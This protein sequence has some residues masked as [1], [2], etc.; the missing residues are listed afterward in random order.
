[1][2][3]A[4]ARADAS[5]RQAR[6]LERVRDFAAS[7]SQKLTSHYPEL[8]QGNAHE[9]EFFRVRHFSSSTST[10]LDD[11]HCRQSAEATGGFKGIFD[12]AHY[13]EVTDIAQDR[14]TRAAVEV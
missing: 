3:S 6:V 8:G 2:L 7:T 4:I 10:R 12:A 1:M 9:G 14:G 13:A 5:A 11:S